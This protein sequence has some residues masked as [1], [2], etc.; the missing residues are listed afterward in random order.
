[1]SPTGGGTGANRLEE[2]I[3]LLLTKYPLAD[4]LKTLERLTAR[5]R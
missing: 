4:V 2:E 1:M 3:K 5:A